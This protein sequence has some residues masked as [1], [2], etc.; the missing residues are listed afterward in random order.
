[1]MKDIKTQIS[2][3][4]TIKKQVIENLNKTGLNPD[5]ILKV[6]KEVSQLERCLEILN[7]E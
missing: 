7:E 1:M 5:R 6:E 4:V 3:S 2:G